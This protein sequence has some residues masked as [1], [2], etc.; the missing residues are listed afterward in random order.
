MKKLILILLVPFLLSLTSN[1]PK[2]TLRWG[3]IG[4][5][6]EI[7]FD[8]TEILVGEWL[9]YICY[10]NPIEISQYLGSRNVKLKH[11][12]SQEIEVLKEKYYPQSLLP[13]TSLI[14]ELGLNYLFKKRKKTTL[15]K[16]NG[17][18]GS[19]ILPIDSI[20]LLNRKKLYQDLKRPIVGISYLQATA[21]CNWR[22][23]NEIIKYKNAKSHLDSVS[24]DYFEYFQFSLPTQEDLALINT[25]KDSISSKGF[26]NFNY[27][28]SIK[29]SKKY[30]YSHCGETTLTPWHK[31]FRNAFYYPPKF[32]FSGMEH[33]QGNVAEMSIKKGICYGG[34]YEHYAKKSYSHIPTN[35]SGPKKW[36]GFRCVG[37]KLGITQK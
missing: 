9:E 8:E 32:I 23:N 11:L 27:R 29:K 37:R 28:Q 3:L 2:T 25:N 24:L 34:S 4:Q 33:V 16:Y 14:K 10:N 26:S 17:L 1:K 19:I 12:N 36:L 30:P 18:D 20:E 22:T 15:I 6:H 5:K 35:Y 21:F 7:V 13:D 31:V